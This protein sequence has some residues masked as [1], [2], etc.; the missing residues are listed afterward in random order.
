MQ[1]ICK[2]INWLY[3]WLPILLGCHCRPN[4]SFFI[5]GIQMPVCVRCEGQI[6][7]FAAAIISIY[8]GT[9][10]VIF[11]ILLLLPLICD[12]L[13]QART[14]YESNNWTRLITGIL[15][16]YALTS[17]ILLSM[18]ATFQWGYNLGLSWHLNQPQFKLIY[19]LNEHG[20]K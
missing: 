9:L 19:C 6:A 1:I 7:G 5:K 14:S 18:I 10:P 16:G 12:G 4:R 15:F 2:G 8:F 13:I 20:E 3:K 11:L 17:L